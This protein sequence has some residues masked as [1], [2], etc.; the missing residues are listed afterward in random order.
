MSNAHAHLFLVPTL[1]ALGIAGAEDQVPARETLVITGTRTPYA[2]DQAPVR[3]EVISSTLIKDK[4][5]RTLY[6]ALEGVPGV[7][8]EEQCSACNFSHIRV[9]GLD[10]GRTQVLIDS[11]QLFT[12][13]AS[14]YG[15]Q[16]IPASSIERIEITKGS[17]SAL[18]GGSSLGGV[19]NIITRDPTEPGG[20]I[21]LSVGE[22][23]TLTFQGDAT[24]VKGDGALI[25]TVQKSLADAIDENGD[26]LTDRVETD[27]LASG[28]RATVGNVAGGTLRAALRFIQDDRR[29]GEL[30]TIE[31]PFAEGS[32]HINTS[33]YDGTLAYELPVGKDDLVSVDIGYGHHWRSATNDTFVVDYADLIATPVPA[34]ELEPYLAEEDQ[35]IAGARYTLVRGDHTIMVGLSGVVNLLEESGKYVDPDLVQA[36]RSSSDKRTLEGGL[37]VQDEWRVN[38]AWQVVVGARVDYHDSQEVY[39]NNLAGGPPTLTSDYDNTAVNPRL[40]LKYAVDPK[41]T[42]RA[43]AGSGTRVAYGFSEDLLLVSGSPRAYKANDLDPERSYSGSLSGDWNDDAFDVGINLFY[44]RLTDA[45]TFTDAGAQAASLGYDYEFVNVGDAYT[46]GIEASLQIEV[47]KDFQVSVNG[48]Y[49]LGEYDDARP[50]WIG[51]PDEEDSKKI[52]RLPDWTLGLDLAYAPQAW[53]FALGAYVTGPMWIDYLSETPGDEEI[54]RT[55]AY[56]VVNAKVTHTWNGMRFTVGA[57]NLFDEVQDDRRTDD[58][59]FIYAPL[60]GRIVYGGVDYTF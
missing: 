56:V 24:L 51:T 34:D 35:F 9:Q 7:R 28:L 1:V 12:G 6:E 55:D 45:I 48:T 8:V 13:L 11:H 14:V 18:Y 54:V 49:T 20:Q 2:I 33:R 37:Y 26:G 58:T 27:T 60:W 5:A 39:R 10:V 17:G 29:G 47:V 40:A 25:A 41:L 42:L 50:D 57:R 23:N 59:A 16:H 3:T 46:A 52:S 21:G 19:V 32:E 38:D 22:H 31:N 36:Y 30:S 15:L 53:R 4:G 43:S 44:N